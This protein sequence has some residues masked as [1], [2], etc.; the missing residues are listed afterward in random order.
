MI[1]WFENS[2]YN[3]AGVEYKKYIHYICTDGPLVIKKGTHNA[4]KAKVFCEIRSVGGIVDSTNQEDSPQS[5][6]TEVKFRL[7]KDAKIEIPKD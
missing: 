6:T 1:Y 4:L 7:P 5:I 2:I 3:K